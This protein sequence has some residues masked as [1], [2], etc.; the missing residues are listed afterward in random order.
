[1]EMK[2]SKCTC[3]P[4][5]NYQA[6]MSSHKRNGSNTPAMITKP[7]AFEAENCGSYCK[8]L[9]AGQQRRI[10]TDLIHKEQLK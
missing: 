4:Q 1:M 8:R 6:A 7:S 3:L 5:F 10:I 2:G 9:T